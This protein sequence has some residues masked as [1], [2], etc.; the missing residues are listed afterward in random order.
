[1]SQAIGRD[2]QLSIAAAPPA[3]A[4]APGARHFRLACDEGFDGDPY[5]GLS[6]GRLG[7][8]SMAIE[9]LARGHGRDPTRATSWGFD[10]GSVVTAPEGYLT[11]AEHA[12]VTAGS[13]TLVRELR[14][15]FTTAVAVDY[16]RAA[17]GALGHKVIAHHSELLC[18][19]GICLEIFELAPSTETTGR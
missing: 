6:E 12:L 13:A 8:L 16:L 19:S 7:A 10:D 18:Q 4:A 11:R 17:E 5:N 2:R 1:M 3:L 9:Q 15:A 14:V